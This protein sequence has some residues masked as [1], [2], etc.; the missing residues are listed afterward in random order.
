MTTKLIPVKHTVTS[1]QKM[2]NFWCNCL[3]DIHEVA[4]LQGRLGSNCLQLVEYV[5]CQSNPKM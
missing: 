5:A 2:Y 1:N 4:E 3:F